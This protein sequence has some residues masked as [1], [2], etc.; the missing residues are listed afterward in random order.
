M[1]QI[2]GT[3][4]AFIVVCLV[5]SGWAAPAASTI[6]Y[7]GYLSD[8]NGDALQD[9]DYEITFRIYNVLSGGAALWTETWSGADLVPVVRGRFSVN[10]GSITSFESAGLTFDEQYYLVFLIVTPAIWT[11]VRTRATPMIRSSCPI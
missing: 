10:L 8:A 4:L 3:V 7:Q 2:A 1:K 5:S 9:G 11:M 6:N